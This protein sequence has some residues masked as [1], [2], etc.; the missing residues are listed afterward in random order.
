MPFSYSFSVIDLLFN[1]NLSFFDM[2]IKRLYLNL[3][4]ILI[5]KH[6]LFIVFRYYMAFS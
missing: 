3:P 1:N 6:H 4:N 5:E 2:Q